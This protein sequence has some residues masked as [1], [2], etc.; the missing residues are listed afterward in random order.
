VTT[1]RTLTVL[2]WAALLGLACGGPG[3]GGGPSAGAI[4]SSASQA[5]TAQV[6]AVPLFWASYQLN[7]EPHY[8]L[9]FEGGS[10]GLKP[11]SVRITDLTG[12]PL[13]GADTVPS[14][15]ET[16]RLCGATRQAP[17]TLYGPVRAT[18]IVD[19][20]LFTDFSF[21]RSSDYK[22][23]VRIGTSWLPAVLTNLCHA[24]A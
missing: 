6:E 16:L 21:K 18:V 9:I 24:Q 22:V 17:P 23:E 19:E 13:A 3:G 2:A 12:K 5:A 4:A 15:A 8:R 14:A 1:I 7:Q 20:T 11:E 10:D